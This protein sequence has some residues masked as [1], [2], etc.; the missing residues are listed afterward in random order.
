ME[1][2]EK[3]EVYGENSQRNFDRSKMTGKSGPCFYGED[4]GHK[5][6]NCWNKWK[7]VKCFG[8]K[9]LGHNATNCPEIIEKHQGTSTSRNVTINEVTPSTPLSLRTNEVSLVTVLDTRSD[10]NTIRKDIFHK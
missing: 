4:K 7:G 2:K 5:S 8:C 1:E 10:I 9:D 3:V 6:G